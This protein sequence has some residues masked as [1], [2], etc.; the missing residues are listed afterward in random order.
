[1][2]IVCVFER[3]RE[4]EREREREILCASVCLRACEREGVKSGGHTDSF[5]VLPMKIYDT[6]GQVTAPV[7][8][9]RSCADAACRHRNYLLGSDMIADPSLRQTFIMAHRE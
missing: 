6:G 2:V 8:P 9:T 4:R 1:M 3:D 5:T 7:M